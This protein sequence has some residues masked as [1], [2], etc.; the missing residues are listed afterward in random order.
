MHYGMDAWRSYRDDLL[1]EREREAMEGHLESCD[2]C[3]AVYLKALQPTIARA[4]VQSESDWERSQATADLVMR[5]LASATSEAAEA[6]E[7]PLPSSIRRPERW[8][9]SRLPVW[10]ISPHE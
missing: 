9:E 4:A 6:A 2:C 8:F 5:R 10:R 1:P 7:A 3:L